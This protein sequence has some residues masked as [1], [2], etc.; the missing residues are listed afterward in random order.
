M[1]EEQGEALPVVLEEKW[2]RWF[3]K[4]VHVMD[5]WKWGSDQV[6]LGF[7]FPGLVCPLVE[8]QG[9]S[10]RPKEREPEIR[11]RKRKEIGE[12]WALLS[13]C[14]SSRSGCVLTGHLGGLRLLVPNPHSRTGYHVIPRLNHM[15]LHV[16]LISN[17]NLQGIFI[18]TQCL[19]SLKKAHEDCLWRI[20]LQLRRLTFPLPVSLA[21]APPIPVFH[22]KNAHRH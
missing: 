8:V 21:W 6:H 16:V 2:A 17:R 19:P 1:S 14:V 7:P 11:S 5:E 3:L 12:Y 13:V 4:P 20:H 10:L 18:W 9:K 22:N 15:P